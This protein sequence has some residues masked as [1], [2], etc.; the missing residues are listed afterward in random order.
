ME[1]GFLN[2][3]NKAS[4]KR[5]G[6]EGSLISDLA[7]KVK[8]IDGKILRKDGKPMLPYRCVKN[9]VT[10]T[11]LVDDV[12][13]VKES[14]KD[15]C[16][17]GCPK[18]ASI[19]I[20]NNHGAAGV[21]NEESD[22]HTHC[23]GSKVMGENTPAAQ[24]D[25]V[26]LSLADVIIPQ[27]E[28]DTLSAH[29]ENSLYGY[30]FSTKDGMENV[31]NQGPWRIRSVPLI[32]NVWNPNSELKKEDIKKVHV[33][34]KVGLNLITSKLGRLLMLDAHTSNMCLNSWGM[35]SYARALVEIST[36]NEFVESL[37]V[38]V[39]IAKTKGHRMVTIDIEFEY[40]PP[41]CSFCKVFDHVE[42]ECHKKEKE[43]IRNESMDDDTSKPKVNLASK[44][45]MNLACEKSST[46]SNV[47]ND[48]S[49]R[50][51]TENAKSNYIQDDIDLVEES[52]NDKGRLLEQFLKSREASK[53]KHHSLSDSDDSEVE[54]V[55]ITD[56]IPGGGF[57]DGLKADLDGYDG[58]KAP[59]YDLN[60]QEQAFYDQYDIRL[61]SRRRK[62]FVG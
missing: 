28:V 43:E 51:T 34:S 15:D 61:N 33:Y 17:V 59:V 42:K 45:D 24:E 7:K 56:P 10:F 41:R 52:G 6:K 23:V 36:E 21:T 49:I 22:T 60:E 46:C 25:A 9:K 53:D 19:G 55:C 31:L 4:M 37:V 20:D 14:M 57:L 27:E 8:N 50:P 13:V 40:K 18:P 1:Q 32:L 38:A 47:T 39:P 5:D 35:Y 44:E 3:S 48:D 12:A 54:E 26:V 16:E 2:R 11:D 29:F 62:S 30:F 58:Y